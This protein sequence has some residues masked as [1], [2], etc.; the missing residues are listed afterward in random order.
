MQK[1]EN[2]REKPSLKKVIPKM[3]ALQEKLDGNFIDLANFSREIYKCSNLSSKIFLT[4]SDLQPRLLM[5]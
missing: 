3:S 4:G 2:L 1:S 5:E